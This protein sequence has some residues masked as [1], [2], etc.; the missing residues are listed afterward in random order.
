MLSWYAFTL[1]VEVRSVRSNYDM[2]I[3]KL[4]GILLKILIENQFNT[5]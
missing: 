4:T 3:L 5:A 1:M 2:N